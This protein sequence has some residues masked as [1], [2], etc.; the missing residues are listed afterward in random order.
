MVFSETMSTLDTRIRAELDRVALRLP[1]SCHGHSKADPI[2]G[3]P[4]A[5]P[6]Q[7]DPGGLQARADGQQVEVHTFVGDLVRILARPACQRL[8]DGEQ[9]APA[10]P[11]RR[12]YEHPS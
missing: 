8:F 7:T 9:R 12:V 11:E 5:R 6:F 10:E 2:G 3:P 1:A 4:D